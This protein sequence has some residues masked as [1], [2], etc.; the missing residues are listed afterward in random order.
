MKVPEPSNIVTSMTPVPINRVAFGVRFE[1]R[2]TLLDTLGA[3]V[4]RIL[5]S[6]GTPF[7]PT[8][9]PLSTRTPNEQALLNEDTGSL[10]RLSQSDALLSLSLDTRMVADINPIAND[11]QQFVLENLRQLAKVRNIIRYGVL[12]ELRECKASLALAPIERYVQQDFKDARSLSLRF[13]R[14][15]P[16]LE[17]LAKRSVDDFRNVIYTIKESESGEVR[18]LIDY[19]EYF[20]PHLSA[21]EWDKRSFPRFVE[22]GIGYYEGEFQLW[23]KNFNKEDEAA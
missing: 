1:P 5:R 13:T 7:G 20:D 23:L 18:I 11:F 10:L 3:V 12:F 14:R 21:K 4:D 6:P 16:S 2:Y 19:Q 15:L 17:A 22:R 8:V 9:F